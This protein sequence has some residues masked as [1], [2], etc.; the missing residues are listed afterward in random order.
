MKR[1]LIKAALFSN[2]HLHEESREEI[3][4]RWE[5]AAERIRKV[6]PDGS[7]AYACFLRVMNLE[8]KNKKK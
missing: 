3:D 6:D 5:K 8:E 1:R 7:R 2:D 4:D